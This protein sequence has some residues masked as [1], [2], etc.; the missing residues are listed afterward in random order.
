LLKSIVLSFYFLFYPPS[1]GRS[2][3]EREEEEERKNIID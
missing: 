1:Q 3:G 2:E